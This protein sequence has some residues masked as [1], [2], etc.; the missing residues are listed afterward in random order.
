MKIS[1]LI[2]RLKEIKRDHGDLKVTNNSFY[3]G[4][5]ELEEQNLQIRHMKRLS[6]RESKP[7]YWE[8]ELTE[9]KIEET[10]GEKVLSLW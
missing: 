5:M 6:K 3:G 1:T 10:K 9:N 8:Y 4:V 2:G 7:K